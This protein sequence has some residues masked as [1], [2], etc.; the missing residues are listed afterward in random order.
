MPKIASH[1]FSRNRMLTYKRRVPEEVR[2]LGGFGG[3][4]H[5]QKS[6]GT[7][8]PAAARKKAVEFDAIFEKECA[9]YLGTTTGQPPRPAVEIQAVVTDALLLELQRRYFDQT[10]KR[11]RENRLRAELDPVLQ[12]WQDTED[13]YWSQVDYSKHPKRHYLE[14]KARNRELAKLRAEVDGEITA[15]ATKLGVKE[16]SFDYLRIERTYVEAAKQVLEAQRGMRPGDYLTREHAPKSAHTDRLLLKSAWTLR[17]VANDYNITNGKGESWKHKIEITL[18]L[19]ERYLCTPR[20]ISEISREDIRRFIG[21]LIHYPQNAQQRFPKLSIEDAIKANRAR[22]KPFPTISANT[23]R[24]SHLAVLRALFGYAVDHLEAIPV[25][26]VQRVKVPGAVKNAGKTAHFEVDELNT[27][28]RQPWFVGCKSKNRT[29]QPGEVRLREHTYWVPLL[30][31][32]TG[33]RPSELAQL[34]VSDIKIDD[35]FPSIGI[36][37][38]F[39][40][41]DPLDRPFVKAFKSENARRQIPRHPALQDLGFDDFVR[42]QRDAGHVRLFPGWEASSDERKLYTAARWVRNFNEKLVPNVSSRTPNP[43]LYSFRH[44]F[45]TQLAI[46]GIPPQYQNQIMGHA[47]VGMDAHYL[48]VLP[49]AELATA[50]DKLAYGGLDLSHLTT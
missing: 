25:S 50:M 48:G 19:F 12:Q 17:S 5:F 27:L 30:L 38:E 4:T 47:G 16:G 32:Y 29:L 37:T 44:T 33:A 24:D 35:K 20:P 45:K 49:V 11:D 7:T 6:L 46:C 28:F 1:I 3:A 8:D 23:I 26:P 40:A 15:A 41:S 9:N 34:A 13:E 43:T 21:L 36:L 18:T 2:K 39:D 22:T 31:L 14:E 10:M 42:A